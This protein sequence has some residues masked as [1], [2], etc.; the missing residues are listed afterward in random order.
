V[1]HRRGALASGFDADLVAWDVDP[2]LAGGDPRAIR[3]ARARLTV[4]AG[5]VVMQR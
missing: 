1:A 3:H 4:V 2:A 5:E